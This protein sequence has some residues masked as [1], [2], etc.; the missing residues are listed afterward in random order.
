MNILKVFASS[1]LVAITFSALP[2]IH[3]MDDEQ[4][5]PTRMPLHNQRIE[6]GLPLSGNSNT[7]RQR[8]HM[9]IYQLDRGTSAPLGLEILKRELQIRVVQEILA[10]K[11]VSI[12]D[13]IDI[14]EMFRKSNSASRLE[15]CSIDV[16]RIYSGRLRDLERLV[17][18]FNADDLTAIRAIKEQQYHALKI[19]E[20]NEEVLG[21]FYKELYS[22]TLRTQAPKKGEKVPADSY[23][24]SRRQL[25]RLI[26]RDIIESMKL[27]YELHKVTHAEWNRFSQLDQEKAFCSLS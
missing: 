14:Y 10:M 26:K 9:H 13:C 27:Y 2:P 4:N 3:S 12:N 25:T 7:L 20:T 22:G 15:M 19:R 24:G 1:V 16:K 21:K 17:S 6:E 8:V 11:E 23:Q 18:H 5:D